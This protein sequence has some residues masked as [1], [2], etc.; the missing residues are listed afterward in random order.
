MKKR[1]SPLLCGRSWEKINDG[2][3]ICNFG[4]ETNQQGSLVYSIILN[5]EEKKVLL[6]NHGKCK[7]S[8]HCMKFLGASVIQLLIGNHFSA[9]SHRDHDLLPT[10]H[11][12]NRDHLHNQLAYQVLSSWVQVFFSYW[13]V[14]ISSTQGH[15]NLDLWPTDLKINRGHLLV[16]TD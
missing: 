6:I 10:D 4:L 16:M 12:I 15:G 14:T 7:R 3:E 11:N 8:L 1:L 13:A 5:S 2:H 9:H